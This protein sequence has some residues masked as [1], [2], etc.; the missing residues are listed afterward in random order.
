M[1]FFFHYNKPASK[2][3]GKPRITVHLQGKCHLVENLD[4]HVPTYGRIRKT[5]PFFVMAGDA[6]EWEIDGNVMIL[7]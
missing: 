6:N 5:Q 3:A 2:K 1:K 7:R 4:V